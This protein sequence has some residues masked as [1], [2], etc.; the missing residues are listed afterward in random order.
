MSIH[1]TIDELAREAAAVTREVAE[2]RAVPPADLDGFA[3]QLRPRRTLRVAAV[4]AAICL[5]VVA[6]GTL[7]NELRDGPS[8][9]VISDADDRQDVEDDGQVLEDVAPPPAV[10]R[11]GGWEWDWALS[12]VT[13]PDVFAGPGPARVSGIAIPTERVVVAVG[14]SPSLS[15]SGQPRPGVWV[16]RDAGASWSAIAPEAIELPDGS[17]PDASV[18][19]HDVA[20]AGARLIAVGDEAGESGERGV[21][22]ASDDGGD[23]WQVVHRTGEGA[24]GRL[25]AVTTTW[26]RVPEP[27]GSSSQAAGFVAVGSHAPE[28]GARSTAAAWTSPDGDDWSQPQLLPDAPPGVT[29][30]SIA[31][32]EWSR[33]IVVVGVRDPGAGRARDGETRAWVSVDHGAS[34]RAEPLADD[35]DLTAVAHVGSHGWLAVGATRASASGGEDRDGVVYTSGDGAH[36]EP[37]ADPLDELA[38]PGAQVLHAATYGEGFD[39]YV[40]VGV[41]DGRP[42]IWVSPDLDSWRRLPSEELFPAGTPTGITAVGYWGRIIAI[43]ELPRAGV[44]ELA[45]WRS[46]SK[47]SVEGSTGAA[48]AE[49]SDAPPPIE[50]AHDAIWTS[51]PEVSGEEAIRQFAAAAFGWHEL[52]LPSGDHTSGTIAITGPEGDTVEFGFSARDD[53]ERWQIVQVGHGSFS[54]GG[55]VLTLGSPAPL[56]AASADLFLR[57]GGRTWHLLLR[58][59]GALQGHVDLVGS[60]LPT[61][62]VRSVLLVYRDEAGAVIGAEG[63][64]W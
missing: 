53:N 44:T 10:V 31:A 33:S 27:G 26:I 37:A 29:P 18:V 7:A 35:V 36:W 50:L 63:G 52:T 17:A 3:A 2:R 25:V 9:P 13:D 46:V 4:V 24:P 14:V 55:G 43:G 22:W 6:A 8:V 12:R 47:E 1:R 21:V 61:G 56:D 60:G 59:Y 30:S 51:P 58:G 49:L 32:D 23:T 28:A 57:S 64:H 15:S 34:W 38:G 16:S 19:M 11:N 40:V 39:P 20:A 54:A 5:A 48:V 45:V 62:G 42:A 41:D